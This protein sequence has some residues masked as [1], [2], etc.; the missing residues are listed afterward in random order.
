MP[1][2]SPRRGLW[3]LVHLLAASLVLIALMMAG[4]WWWSGTE[5]SLDW[6]LKRFGQEHGLQSE[7]VTGSLRSGLRVK[8]MLWERDGLRVEAHDVHLEWAPTALVTRTVQLDEFRARLVRV[9]DQRPPTGEPFRLPENIALPMR[10]R[11]NE[12]AVGRIEWRGPAE[13]TADQLAGAYL[14]D[15]LG[16][17]LRLDSLRIA[18]G[19]YQGDARLGI[20]GDRPFESTLRGTV[21]TSVP[22]STA[23]VPLQL[24]ATAKGPVADFRALAR[25]HVTQ[26]KPDAATPRGTITARIT[27]F[28]AQPVPEAHAQLRSIDLSAFWPDAPASLLSGEAKL[29]PVGADAWRWDADIVNGAAGPWDAGRLPLER[30]DARGEWR[31]KSV[32]V[33]SLRADVGGGSI[34]AQGRWRGNEAWTVEG[35][36]S[37]VDPA[38]VHTAMVA[39]PLAGKA[40][41]SQDAQGMDF[42]VDLQAQGKPRKR[43]APRKPAAAGDIAATVAALELREVKARGRWSDGTVTLPMLDVRSRDARLNGQLTL[44]T[45]SWAGDG[46]L[47]LEAPGLR[48]S[49]TGR[50][51][52]TAGDG[53]LQMRAPDLARA[54]AWLDTLPAVGGVAG[55]WRATGAAT[56]DVSWRGGWRDPALQGRLATQ[57]LQV[58]QAKAPAAAAWTFRDA[59]LTVNGRLSDAQL[60]LRAQAEQG[61]R[62]V[63]LQVA[64]RAGRADLRQ[65]AVWRANLPEFVLAVRDPS[66]GGGDGAWRLEARRPVQAR[67]LTEPGRLE[68]SPGEALLTAPVVAAPSPGARQAVLNWQATTWG[69]GNLQTAGS[70]SG[71]PMA[72]LSL[73]GTQMAGAGLSGDLVFDAQWRASFGR[74]LQLQ[75][76]L[77]RRSG[78]VNVLAETVDGGS[79]R[80]AAGVRDARLTLEGRGENLTLTLRW[81]SARAGTVDARLV[82]RLAPGGPAG[83][84]W[85]EQAPLGGFVRAQLPKIGVW[86]LLAP[87][88]WRLRGSLSADVALGGVRSDPRFTGTLSADDLALRSVV[89]GVELRGGRLRARLDGQRLQV[90]EFV[91]YGGEEGAAPGS[92]VAR[93]EGTWTP[94]GPVLNATATLTRL[95]ASIRDDRNITVSGQLSARVDAKGTD[96]RGRLVVDQA[97]IV[98]PD[99]LPPR[100]GDDVVVRRAEGNMATAAERKQREPEK[101]PPKRPFNVVVEVD[102]GQDFRLT[103]RGLNT[104]LRGEL[105]L[106]AE[107]L[108]QP[109]LTGSIRT[110][111]GEYRAYGQQLEIERGI[112]RFTGPLD[113]PALDILAVRPRLVQTVGVQITGTVQSPFIRLYSQ[114]E[115]PDAEKLAWLVTGRAAPSGGAEAALVQQAAMAL[116]ANRR[117]GNGGGIAGRIGLDELS[118]RRDDTAGAV[119]TLGKRFADNFYASYERS[120]SGALGTLYIF[121]DISRRLTL[122]AEA[123]ERTAVD[124]IYTFSF[125]GPGRRRGEPQR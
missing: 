70:L 52:E 88:G 16:H 29:Q 45:R 13:A 8:R 11:A 123:G 102:L 112:L 14:F 73:L 120:L 107:T 71:L 38:A 111:G 76:S 64:G 27:P 56:L 4:L 12:V 125:D 91:L 25:L 36:V 49:G 114:P 1:G 86:S 48:A 30:V 5:G 18:G 78:D 67:W 65:G 116:L 44:N 115:M 108:S 37:G 55:D 46:R 104:T 124:L 32:L 20:L 10:V 15:G 110:A 26:A 85:P 69:G 60:A 118:V 89:E 119:V 105:Q 93:G 61:A 100:L 9:T 3:F 43:A 79:T 6:M 62:R 84:H 101:P 66:L 21:T 47:K 19:T 80:V 34:T 23:T 42:D 35:T 106:A 96:V 2:F 50:M 98:L 63:N 77:A 99:E 24:E 92:V 109:R 87:P 121:Y 54:Q 95:R 53:S 81:D 103:G 83:W 72:W 40:T 51:S 74:T 117:G 90:D 94:Q 68:L 122:R 22:G 58:K 39:L 28:A 41:L 7:G 57:R 82:T 17:E 113:N 33:Q 59:S 97:R 75:A 31:G